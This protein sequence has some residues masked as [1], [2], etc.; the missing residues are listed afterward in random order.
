MWRSMRPICSAL[1][2]CA[3]TSSLGC[4]PARFVTLDL[5]P[6]KDADGIHDVQ[7]SSINALTIHVINLADHAS[8]T[9]FLG[10][11]RTHAKTDQQ[12]LAIPLGGSTQLFFD[13]RGCAATDA[14]PDTAVTFRGCA[15]LA[16]TSTDGAREALAVQMLHADDARLGSLCASATP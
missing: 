13:V 14:C 5:L 12:Q 1:A 7:T 3:V 8:T 11:I 6:G 9:Y 4:G 15:S 2:L 16:P 10:D